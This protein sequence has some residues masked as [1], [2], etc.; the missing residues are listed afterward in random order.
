MHLVLT[1]VEMVL[2]AAHELLK[3]SRTEKLGRG[4]ILGVSKCVLKSL[5]PYA[6]AASYASIC[7]AAPDW[8]ELIPSKEVWFQ[9]VVKT[10]QDDARHKV[11]C[12]KD[13]DFGF[14]PV[15]VKI[16]HNHFQH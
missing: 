15:F 11:F 8:T 13:S 6:F 1:K 3:E 12:F 4:I 14:R 7:H 2:E 10:W 9:E 5:T 16:N